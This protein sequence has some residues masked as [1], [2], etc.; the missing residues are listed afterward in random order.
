[1][2]KLNNFIV[3]RNNSEKMRLKNECLDDNTAL[4]NKE[5]TEYEKKLIQVLTDLNTLVIE[6]VEKASFSDGVIIGK[7]SQISKNV[8]EQSNILLKGSN[9]VDVISSNM[10]E[11]NQI[12][13]NVSSSTNN[14]HEL[15]NNGNQVVQELS[16]QMTVVEKMF[17]EFL[18]VFI[19]LKKNS[20]QIVDFTKTIKGIVSQTNMLSLNASIEAAR[21]G[22]H[23]KG[24]AIV[25]NEVKSL[26][27]QI[28][29]ASNEIEENINGIRKKMDI[30]YNKTQTGTQEVTKG[31][32]LMGTTEEFFNSFMTTES[33]VNKGIYEISSS[34]K[35]ISSNIINAADS[36]KKISEKSKDSAGSL[37]DLVITSEEKNILF[38]DL[39][40]FVYQMEDLINEL[41]TSSCKTK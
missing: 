19:S 17:K 39:I 9:S 27:E 22:E 32:E 26:S 20:E 25:A 14:T 21:A 16:M 12:I 31:I 33:N 8:K 29:K 5:K 34:T 24:F 37:E 1:M 35:D 28:G 15:A 7:T 4:E 11:I 18:E 36:L 2:F 10:E 38:N 6:T 41:K 23:G 3:K 13:K 30:L 40:S